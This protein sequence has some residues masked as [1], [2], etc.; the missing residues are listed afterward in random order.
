ML[1]FQPVRS[2]PQRRACLTVYRDAMDYFARCG[3]PYPGRST[4]E[5]D[6]TTMPEAPHGEKVYAL[7]MRDGTVVGVIAYVLAA[8]GPREVTL[9]LLL[10]PT[11]VRNQ[12]IGTQALAQLQMLA[13][14]AGMQRLVVTLINPKNADAAFWQ[15][16]GFRVVGQAREALAAGVYRRVVR[17]SAPVRVP[18]TV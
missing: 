12:G 6:R 17:L 8:P 4:V 1:K 11:Q 16:R 10:V 3:A 2:M 18:V 5:D 7:V 15:H 9:E 13:A 14:A